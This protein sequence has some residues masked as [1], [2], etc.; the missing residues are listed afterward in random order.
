MAVS[1][2]MDEEKAKKEIASL[3]EEIE[4]HNKRYYLDAAPE[5]SDRDYDRLMD[6][7]IALEQEY[8]ELITPDSPSQRVGGEPLKKFAS[9][10]HK[11]P[12]MSLD[13][14][15]NS[16]EL[17]KFDERVKKGLGGEAPEYIVE[18]KYDGVAVALKYE[19]GVLIQGSTRGDGKK[20]DDITA[21]L[22]TIKSLPLRLTREETLEVRGEV[23]IDKKDLEEINLERDQNGE[24]LFANPRNAAA[25]SLKLLDPGI[26]AKRPL[27]LYIYTLISDTIMVD[28]QYDAL[29]HV[30]KLGFRIQLEYPKPLDDIGQV[31]TYCRKDL[32]GAR[33]T[34]PFEVDGAVV[35]V[36]SFAQQERLGATSKS[37]RWAISYKFE[38]Q[39]VQT[40]LEK[41]TLQVG[42]TG[43]ITPVA[44][45]VSQDIAGSTVSRATL[46]NAD[47]I[48][49]KDI[50][51]GDVVTIEKAGA[52]IP[53]VVE[54]FEPSKKQRDAN[55]RPFIFPEK[56]PSCH[57]ALTRPEG[58]VVHRCLNISCPAQFLR[59][60]Q[61][62]VARDAMDIEGLGPQTLEL[63]VEQRMV[64]DFSDLYSLDPLKLA[65]LPRM[66]EKSAENLKESLARS[67]GHG[68]SRLLFALG[69]RHVGRQTAESL[70]EHFSSLEKLARAAEEELVEVNDVGPEVAQSLLSF[71]AHA[72]NQLI[73]ERLKA[74]GLSLNAPQ[75]VVGKLSGKVFL[76]T[77]GLAD[78]SRPQAGEKVRALGGRVVSAVSAKVDFVVA[79]EDPGSKA[80]KAEKLGLK[81]I[82]EAEFLQL[83]K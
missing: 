83:I 37:P 73:I 3:R 16:D 53:K 60:L 35:K 9:V 41:I 48:A 24:P 75:R 4:R 28:N 80:K 55:S 11:V 1:K 27:K 6:R 79:G 5:I 77:G 29:G 17:I 42:R 62:F 18:L 12:M 71:F 19:Q 78:Y 21:N 44:E 45:L 52:V 61:H 49:R 23:Y 56:C 38:V 14:T 40:R 59:R 69:P 68:M 51:E 22:R 31:T 57:G 72:D 34:F 76:F 30:N 7:L 74:A 54:V 58:E 13:N 70:A 47:E 15:Y 32:E 66:G 26:V 81:I 64:N 65:E 8:P 36:N 63:L 33:D 25:G 43:A 39:Q 46:H 82:S 67:K 10:G 50:R 20:G 2:K